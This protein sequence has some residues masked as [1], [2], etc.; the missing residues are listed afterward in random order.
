MVWDLEWGT[1][2]RQKFL[3]T[4]VEQGITPDALRNKPRLRPWLAEY[5]RAFQVLTSSR[6]VG[7]GGVGAIPLSEIAAYFELF[8]V[9]DPDERYAYV[10]M[11]KALDSAYLERTNKASTASVKPV[12]PRKKVAVD[13]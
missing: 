11:I 3:K 7:M 6:S 9:H 13:G 2:E 12:E 8:E 1:P 5:Y 4:L 10:T